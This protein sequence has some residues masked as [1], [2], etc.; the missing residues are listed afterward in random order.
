MLSCHPEVFNNETG[1]SQ[2]VEAATGLKWSSGYH[3]ILNFLIMKLGKVRIL[4][5][6][7]GLNGPHAIMSL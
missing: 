4:K 7:Q 2:N 6:L 1:E 5:Q 3:A